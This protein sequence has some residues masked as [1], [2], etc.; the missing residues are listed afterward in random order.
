MS[1]DDE[2]NATP[3]PLSYTSSVRLLSEYEFDFSVLAARI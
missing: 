2:V 1:I 3:F